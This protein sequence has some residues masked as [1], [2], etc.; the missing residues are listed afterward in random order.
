MRGL[1]G[2]VNFNDRPIPISAAV[3]SDKLKTMIPK[4]QLV[5]MLW[6]VIGMIAVLFVPTLAQAHAGHDHAPPPITSVAPLETTDAGDLNVDLTLSNDDAAVPNTA[7]VASASDFP[8][9]PNRSCHGSC[10]EKGS[11]GCSPVAAPNAP[12]SPV[13]PR[14]ASGIGPFAA[15]FRPGIDPEALPEPPKF[16]T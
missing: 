7:I 6:A 5:T 14:I 4:R 10:C 15:G 1:K 2:H 13:P 11:A 8:F 9:V 12:A 16:F 3:R